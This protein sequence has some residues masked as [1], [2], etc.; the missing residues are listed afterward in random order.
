MTLL[1]LKGICVD[2]MCEVK[3]EYRETINYERGT[4]VLYLRVIRL[5]YGCIEAAL[6]WFKLYTEVLKNLGFEMNLHDF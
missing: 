2:I 3:E 5:I 6:L 4:K 1:K